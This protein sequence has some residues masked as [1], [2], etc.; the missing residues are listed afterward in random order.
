MARAIKRDGIRAQ[1][2]GQLLAKK[3]ELDPAFFDNA[4]A[5]RDEHT[6]DINDEDGEL[7]L[8][9]LL[10]EATKADADESGEEAPA[11]DDEAAE[12]DDTAAE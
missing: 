7:T 8:D 5:K 1:R 2:L 11:T 9:D 12:Q 4:L 6:I 3:A 10:A